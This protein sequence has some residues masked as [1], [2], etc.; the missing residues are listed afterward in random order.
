MAISNAGLT[1]WHHSGFLEFQRER[2]LPYFLVFL[3]GVLGQKLNVFELPKNVKHYIAANVVLTISLTV[4]TAVALNLFFN[5]ITPG[6]NYFFIS[7]LVDRTVYYITSLLSMLSILYVLIHVLRF[8]FNKTNHIMKQLNKNS[9]SVYI[10]HVIVLGVF[11]LVMTRIQIPAFAK[12]LVLTLLTFVVSNVLV[13]A[14][15]RVI[16]KNVVMKVAMASMCVVAF[17]VTTSSGNHLVS[18]TDNAQPAVAQSELPA[19]SIGLHEAVIQGNVEAIRQHISAGSNLNIEDPSGGS[20]P[21]ITAAVFGKTEIA[22]LLIE[23]GAN[24]DFRN[25]EGSTPLITAAFFCNVKIVE[26]LLAH[27][28]DRHIRN[29]EGSKAVDAVIAPYE[30]VKMIYDYFQNSLGPLGLNLDYVQIQKDRPLIAEML[31]T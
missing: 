6:R 29:D 30:D 7:D 19:Q 18:L 28:A 4:F 21:L 25:N 17:F 5:L 14:Y 22:L 11:A 2:L 13:S 20:S 31:K 10:I 24:L 1:G 16:R 23:G 3:L 8:K 27:G 15:D 9:Y 26:A 12:Y